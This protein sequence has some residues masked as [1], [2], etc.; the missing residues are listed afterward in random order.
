MSSEISPSHTALGY[1]GLPLV[2]ETARDLAE[3]P[4]AGA[5]GPRR[6][7]DPPQAADAP[8]GV[9]E[10]AVLLAPGDRRQHHV[11]HLGE[12]AAHG[13]LDDDELGRAQRGQHGVGVAERRGLVG[14]DPD[15]ARARRPPGRRRSRPWTGPAGRAGRPRPRRRPVAAGPRRR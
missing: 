14:P 1:A 6:A 12:V 10:G 3:R 13:A 5:R 11:G 15:G 4:P 8:L 9:G 7:L 2:A